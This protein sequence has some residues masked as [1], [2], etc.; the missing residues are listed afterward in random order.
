MRYF[1]GFTALTAALLLGICFIHGKKQE[2]N[3]NES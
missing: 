3:K 1:L 2:E